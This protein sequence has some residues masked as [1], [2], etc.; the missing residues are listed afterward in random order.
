MSTIQQL[1]KDTCPVARTSAI[2]GRKWTPLIIRDLATGTKRFT[3]LER[4]LARI[5]PK[6][7]SERL[8]DLEKQGIV[9]RE[10]FPE[11]PIRVEY[12]LT[13]KGMALIPLIDV[14]RSYGETWT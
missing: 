2:I 1:A 6:T 8:R 13:E 11:V 3:E 10:A 12:T 4:S 9:K 14:M 5:S 7:L